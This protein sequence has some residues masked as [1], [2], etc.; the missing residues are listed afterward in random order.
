MSKVISSKQAAALI[1][2]GSTIGASVMGL[3]GW[4][5]ELAVEIEKRFEKEGHPRNITLVHS[6]TAG[7][8]DKKGATHLGHEGL[9]KRLYCGNTAGAPNMVRLIQENKIECYFIP[10]GVICQLWRAIAG[11]KPGVI[12]KVGLGTYV[13]PRLE[14]GKITSIT[15]EDLVELIEINGEEWLLYK[16]FPIDVAIIR[17]S[18]ADENGNMTMDREM[19][20]LEALPWPW[21]PKTAAAW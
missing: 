15:K 13:D 12:T 21:P 20:I 16:R 17:G 2:D 14:G 6:S 7:D 19:A 3:A 8:H 18:V 10:Q 5:E 9:V 4:P 1:K 11:N